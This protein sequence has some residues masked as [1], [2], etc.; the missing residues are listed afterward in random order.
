MIGL[1]MNNGIWLVYDYRAYK[2][3]EGSDTR[4]HVRY[5]DGT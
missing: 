5:T 1:K 4:F 3:A 2:I